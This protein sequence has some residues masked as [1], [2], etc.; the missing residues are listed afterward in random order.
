MGSSSDH[1]EDGEGQ[2]GAS[3]N[4][5]GLRG[6]RSLDERGYRLGGLVWLPRLGG[7]GNRHLQHSA[8]RKAKNWRRIGAFDDWT[9]R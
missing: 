3:R 1:A 8:D 4:E 6:R 9:R 2:G 7:L 5:G